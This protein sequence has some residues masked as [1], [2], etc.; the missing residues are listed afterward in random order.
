MITQIFKQGENVI[1]F[2]QPE[3]IEESKKVGLK[4]GQGQRYFINDKETDNIMAVMRFIIDESK[5]NKQ[6]FIPSDM[7]K[8]RE[9]LFK[10]QQKAMDDQVEMVKQHYKSMNAPQ[11]VIDQIDKFHEF[12]QKINMEGV[13][14][15]R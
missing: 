4:P 13:R 5:K 1:R 7:K 10:A 15:K 2:E 9:N 11:E 12:Q 3:T 8:A 6:N 14:T